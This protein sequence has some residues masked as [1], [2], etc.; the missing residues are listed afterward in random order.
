MSDATQNPVLQPAAPDRFVQMVRDDGEV[1]RVEAMDVQHALDQGWQVDGPGARPPPEATDL[2]GSLAAGAAGAARGLSFGISDYA[3]TKTGLVSPDTL[4]AL[5]DE[6][7][8]AS[9]VGELGAVLAS[10]VR[11]TG[12]AGGL[13]QKVESIGAS[14]SDDIARALGTASR[15][16]A[17]KVLTTAASKAGGAASRTGAGKVLTT[18][19]SKAGGAAVEG[20][21]YG[22]GQWL[23]ESSLGETEATTENLIASAGLGALVGGGLGGVF[24]VG[25]QLTKKALEDLGE[26]GSKALASIYERATGTKA[27]EGLGQ[28]WEAISKQ[29]SKAAAVFSNGSEDDIYRFMT[30]KEARK[31]ATAG[32]EVREEAAR[33]MA[34]LIDEFETASAQIEEIGRGAMKREQVAQLIKNGNEDAVSSA[35]HGVVKNIRAKLDELAESPGWHGAGMNRVRKARKL[36]DET[37]KRIIESMAAPGEKAVESANVNVFSTLDDMKR[38]LGEITKVKRGFPTAEEGDAI[39]ALEGIYDDVRLHLETPEL[40][41]A[42]GEAQQAINAKW[43]QFLGSSN[44]FRQNFTTK[45][46]QEGWRPVYKADPG[47]LST[48]INQLTGAKSDLTHQSLRSTLKARKELVEEMAERFELGERGANVQAARDAVEKLTAAVDEIEKTVGLQN[49][50]RQIGEGE[51]RGVVGGLIGTQVGGLAGGA[52]GAGIGEAL[53]RPDRVIKMI[54]ALEQMQSDVGARMV[55]SVGSF[56]TKAS[57]KAGRGASRI[58]DVTGRAGARAA[59][60][61]V[62]STDTAKARRAEFAEAQKT[63]AKWAAAPDLAAGVLTDRTAQLNEVG[64][65]L[66]AA[67]ARK[68]VQAVGYLYEKMPQSLRSIGIDGK[69][70]YMSSDAAAHSWMRRFRAAKDPMTLVSDLR[71]GKVS[72]EAVETVRDLYPT[73]YD[74]LRNTVID[75]V[76]QRGGDMQHWAR[77]QLSILFDAPLDR[78]MEP[79]FIQAMRQTGTAE[80]QQQTPQPQPSPAPITTPERYTTAAGRIAAL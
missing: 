63:V 60:N 50:L 29:Y 18:A 25:G 6:H 47:K 22:A 27:R 71:S 10:M 35:A 55:K 77:V 8:T 11:G 46:G 2:A 58:A 32:N 36:V 15:T 23:S 78:T 34:G 17:G 70:N 56:M 14:V 51:L 59:A 1:V 7:E 26:G 40:Y 52:V 28:A 24:S 76:S 5:K 43:H 39:A 68:G 42:A 57:R 20:A 62:R 72:R 3:L 61:L 21:L 67:M 69:A 12:K 45:V 19:A 38:K 54:A 33:K 37:E 79:S 49:Q 48:F 4:Q 80:P 9:T 64:G 44:L 75:Q 31:M 65:N 13:V 16:G 66:A 74:A 53:T 30:S 73:I 41:G